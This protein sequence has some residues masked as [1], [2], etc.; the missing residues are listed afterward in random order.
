MKPIL[1]LKAS[2]GSGKTTRLVGRYLELLENGANPN[3][4]LCLTF[5]NKAAGEM[6]E[7][8]ILALE[9]SNLAKLKALQSQIN[10][11]PILTF[12]AFF[13]RI[14]R[15]FCFYAGVPMDYEIVSNAFEPEAFFAELGELDRWRVAKFLKEYS[16]SVDALMKNFGE[17]F[18]LPN[19]LQT[20]KVKF[21][22]ER[23]LGFAR[24]IQNEVLSFEG[25]S[26]SAKKSVEFKNVFELLESGKTWLTKDELNE[27]SFFK[28]VNN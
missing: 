21:N 2:A 23:V 20:K 18:E 10:D 12:D 16:V 14:L 3:E 28:K 11:A 19:L 5:T 4:I 15:S 17:F 25:A 24:T 9:K 13:N 7:R 1:A 6:K 8:I 26:E 22:E 27:Y